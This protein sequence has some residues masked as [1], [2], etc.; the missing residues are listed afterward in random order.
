MKNK[1][2]IGLILL[3]SVGSLALCNFIREVNSYTKIIELNWG[4]RLSGSYKEIYSIDSGASF[5]GD[6]DRYHIFQHKPK[7]D[8]SNELDWKSN[9]NKYIEQNII[10]ILE[11][12][13]VPDEYL[14]SFKYK[15]KYYFREE[16]SSM[17]Y[18]LLNDDEG[19]IYVIEDFQ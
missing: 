18:I 9:E 10:Q 11:R 19:L 4:I 2:I 12:L 14:P 5:H 8:I 17:I 13:N 3:V 1:L 7:G 16:N 6:G 15:Y